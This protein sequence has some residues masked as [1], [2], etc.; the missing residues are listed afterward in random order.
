MGKQLIILLVFLTSVGCFS[1]RND[2]SLIVHEKEV[3]K[4]TPTN[5]IA[6][7]YPEFK[8]SKAQSKKVCDSINSDIQEFVSSLLDRYLNEENSEVSTQLYNKELKVDYDLDIF[9]RDY[10]STR[11]TIYSYEGGAHGKT[12]FKCFNYRA[13]KLELLKLGDLLHIKSGKE[14][15]SL[16]KLLLKYFKNPDNCFNE[17]PKIND[18]FQ[19]FS[20]QDDSFVFSFAD[21]S[22]GPYVCGTVEIKIPIWDLKQHGLLKL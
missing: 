19:F 12:Y 17:L 21:Y 5:L 7:K 1:C 9:S 11:F 10:V 13:N 22:L 2:L 8:N 14:M 4:R 20:Y 15:Q 6:V 18:D 3:S 16:N